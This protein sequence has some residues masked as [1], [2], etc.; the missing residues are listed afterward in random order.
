TIGGQ[1]ITCPAGSHGFN[2]I[3]NVCDPLDDNNHGSHVSGTIGAV[4]NNGTGVV[5]VNVVVVAATDNTDSLAWFS[6]YGPSSAHM[7]A[8]GVDVLSTTIGGNYAYLSGTS[9]ATPLVS[10]AALLVLSQ[11]AL[12]TAS[13]KTLLL[14]N[15]DPIPSL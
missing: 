8:P 7:G 3:T 11:C 12:S 10:G 9:M 15:V 6:N 1:S 5:G 13:L 2:A 14:N 4:G